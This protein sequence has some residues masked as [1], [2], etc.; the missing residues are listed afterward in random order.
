METTRKPVAKPKKKMSLQDLKDLY[1]AYDPHK[2]KP[3]RATNKGFVHKV[4]PTW[5]PLK[6]AL[7]PAQWHRAQ[8]AAAN[9]KKEKV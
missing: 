6:S 3:S 5:K 2:F 1:P 7:T 8:R 4:N 9:A